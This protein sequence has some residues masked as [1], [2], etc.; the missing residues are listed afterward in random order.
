M[1]SA[2]FPGP[3]A[4]IDQAKSPSSARSFMSIRSCRAGARS[5]SR[6]RT[7]AQSAAAEAS[8]PDS[9]TRTKPS[10]SPNPPQTYYDIFPETLSSGPPPTGRFT[11]N[12]RALRNEYL[13]R[14]ARSHPDLHPASAKARAEAT[15]ALINQAYRT[16]LDPLLRAQYLLSLRG[17]DVAEDESL[18]VEEPDLLMLVLEAREEIEDAETE[19]DLQAPREVNAERIKKSEDVLQTAFQQDDVELAKREAVRLRYWM[20]IKES[21]DNWEPGKPIVLQ[22]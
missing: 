10:K 16:L 12:L 4:L 21:L 1:S 17:I 6:T 14:Q 20:N 15:S 2:S 11:I 13:R 5:F 3:K 9:Q 7:F 8:Q 22:H 19:A 18:K